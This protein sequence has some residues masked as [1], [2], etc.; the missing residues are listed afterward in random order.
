MGREGVM[1]PGKERSI[2]PRRARRVT[3]GRANDQLLYFTS[4]S[5]TADDRTLVFISD[6]DGPAEARVNLYALDCD[7]GEARRLTDNGEG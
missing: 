7:T 5:L 4:S 6:R 2:G 3:D 1:L